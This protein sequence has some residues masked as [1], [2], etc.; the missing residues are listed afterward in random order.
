MTK[1][2]TNK[3][4][5]TEDTFKQMLEQAQEKK[6]TEG[7]KT[8]C[9]QFETFFANMLMKNMRST[10]IESGLT[11]KRQARGMFEGMLDEKIAEEASKGEGIGIAQMMY[12]QLSKTMSIEED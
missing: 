9:K 12:N 3:A 5:N 6:D 1:I 7:L 2:E 11:E 8:A 10:I 4:N